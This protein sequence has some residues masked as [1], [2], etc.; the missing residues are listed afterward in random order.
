MEFIDD[1]LVKVT[2]V[3]YMINS[4]EMTSVN[5]NFVND[6][7]YEGAK[8]LTE[9]LVANKPEG[10]KVLGEWPTLYEALPYL[11]DQV[12]KSWFEFDHYY[13][14]DAF[15]H[16]ISLIFKGGPKKIFD[17]G[18][19]TG[20]W[21]MACCEYDSD[22]QMTILDLPGQL[23][24]AK[25]N[26]EGRNFSDRIDFFPIDL[27][28]RSQKIPKGS[29]IVWMSQFLDCFSESEI[30]AILLNVHQAVDTDTDIYILETFI[31]NQ[32]FEAAKYSLTATSLYFTTM[33]NGNSKMYSMRHMISIVNEAGFE[34][35]ETTQLKGNNYHT[36]LKCKKKTN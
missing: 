1:E 30:I 3:G 21:S 14:D 11:P 8:H 20:K 25:Q 7:C 28:D 5:I 24:V 27:L 18:G 33:A 32:K 23:N 34:V 9:S 15:L 2:K 10:L 26:V 12:K 16:A 29:D 31:D 36:L 35:V 4:D 22:V 6:V 19:N 17:M 13:S